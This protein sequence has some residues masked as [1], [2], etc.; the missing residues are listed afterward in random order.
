MPADPFTIKRA[1]F[2]QAHALLGSSLPLGLEQI[3]DEIGELERTEI[4]SEI[5]VE[6][7]DRYMPL[8]WAGLFLLLCEVLLS[9]TRFR[10][11]P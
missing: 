10:S 11:L 8:L 2:G 1:K 9:N 3:Y 4:T 5:H 6:Y 7:T